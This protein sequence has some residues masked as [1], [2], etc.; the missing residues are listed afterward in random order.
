MARQLDQLP[1]DTT[2]LARKVAALE[3]QVKELRAA[4]RLTSA[5]VG[6][7]QTAP[8]GSRIVL[9]QE[10]KSLQI[11][12]TDGTTLLAELGPEDSGGGGGLWTRGLQDP[13]NFSAYL[14]SGILQFRPVQNGLVQVPAGLSYDTD[15]F[16]YSDFTLT[17]G[18]VGATDHRALMILESV[19][20]GQ[21]PYI[22][23]QGETST[24]CNFDVLGVMTSSNWSYGQVTINPSAAN[25]P[26]SLAVTGLSLAGSTFYAYA[27][28]QT[29][30]PG[31]NVTGVGVTA[32]TSTGLT[33]WVTRTNTTATVINWMV[34][35]L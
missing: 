33:V 25:T 14:A 26:T 31:T 23:V 28:A 5:T 3:R 17:S 24:Q 8:D 20:A 32:I 13:N 22:Y 7:L 2:T 11:Y 27:T 16:Q 10:S 12:D 18:S 19:Y 29:G 4:R 21:T 35:G 9:S 15:A 1:A 30:A 34:I 6:L